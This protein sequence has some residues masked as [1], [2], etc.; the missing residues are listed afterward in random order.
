MKWAGIEMIITDSMAHGENYKP[1]HQNIQL[2][3]EK[4]SLKNPFYIGDTESDS[5]QSRLV[6]LPFVFVDYGFGTTQNY[7]LT[8]S[9]FSQLTDYFIDAIEFKS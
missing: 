6:P 7:D 1:K 8:F 2:L 9:S 3:I 5:L 4:Y